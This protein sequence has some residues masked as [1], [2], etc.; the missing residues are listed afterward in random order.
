MDEKIKEVL[1]EKNSD[2]VLEHELTYTQTLIDTLKEQ[3]TFVCIP[4]IKEKLNLLKETLD[5]ISDHYTVSEDEDARV[6]HKS[7]ES[8]FFGYKTH[9]GMTEERIITAAV[10][11]SGEKGDGPQLPALIE[12]SRKNG[13]D[14][15]TVIGDSA[16]SGKDNLEKARDEHFE[17]VAKLNP[18]ISQGF[19]KEEGK[20][21]YN[22]DAGMFVCPADHIAIRRA[23]QGR[24]NGA[25]NQAYTYYFDVHKCQCCSKR[26]G[27]YK[28]GAKNAELKQ[29]YGYDRAQPYGLSCMKMQGA[30][31]IFAANLKR[32]LK[33]S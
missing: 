21:D 7:E 29:V 14:V 32:I 22:K 5:D 24:K 25:W 2:D 33:L 1:P 8:S 30:M 9:I 11:T 12:Q 3:E 10:I 23:K 4:Q 27:C 16:Y 6:G 19:R 28:P 13:I 17:L 26:E 18:S 20:F 31:A 15:Q